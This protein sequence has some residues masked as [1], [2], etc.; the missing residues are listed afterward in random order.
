MTSFNLKY[1]SETNLAS[2][3]LPVGPTGRFGCLV[4]ALALYLAQL[5]YIAAVLT[6]DLGLK[7]YFHV[8]SFSVSSLNNFK[9]RVPI[10]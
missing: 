3:V 8:Y 5:I 7:S 4:P 9:S 1:S 6:N 10:H 2:S